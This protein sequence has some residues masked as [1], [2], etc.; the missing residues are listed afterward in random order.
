MDRKSLS[1]NG[2]TRCYIGSTSGVKMTKVIPSSIEVLS[3]EMAVV[4]RRKTGAERLRMASRMFVSARE[5]LTNHL[6]AEYPNWEERRIHQ[7]AARR[8]SHGAV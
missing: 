3:E 5:M 4:L 1:E 6:R 8:L 2:V 7:E